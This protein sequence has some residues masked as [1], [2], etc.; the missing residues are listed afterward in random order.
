MLDCVRFCLGGKGW[1]C[2]AGERR[3]SSPPLQ[4]WMGLLAPPAPSAAMTSREWLKWRVWWRN[5]WLLIAGTCELLTFLTLHRNVLIP[6]SKAKPQLLSMYS[7]SDLLYLSS[8]GRRSGSRI[9][10]SRVGGITVCPPSRHTGVAVKLSLTCC[11]TTCGGSWLAGWKSWF[12]ATGNATPQ[13]GLNWTIVHALDLKYTDKCPFLCTVF[14]GVFV[15]VIG[16]WWKDFWELESRAARLPESLHA[17]LHAAHDASQTWPEQGAPAHSWPAV[18]G[19][20]ESE[21]GWE[22]AGWVWG[23]RQG[24][25]FHFHH[26]QQFR[27]SIQNSKSVFWLVVF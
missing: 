20:W 8:T 14:R 3:W 13:V 15:C 22:A 17:A 27:K 24:A 26:S 1:M 21:G 2:R 7:W 18:P 5:T 16:S 11:L 25:S 19:Q 10:W 9:V 6:E 12:N 23:Y 4:S